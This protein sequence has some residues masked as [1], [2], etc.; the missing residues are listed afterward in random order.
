MISH[1]INYDVGLAAPNIS[2]RSLMGTRSRRGASQVEVG[3]P[4]N[5]ISIRKGAVLHTS[6]G[7]SW[8]WN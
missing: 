6:Y 3:G 4:S 1:V 5:R 7:T 8:S 2:A